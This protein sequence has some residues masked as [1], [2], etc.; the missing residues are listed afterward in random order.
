[1][2]TRKIAIASG[3][4]AALLVGS[5]GGFWIGHRGGDSGNA[6]SG[7][8]ARRPL[9]WVAPM[10]PNYRRNKPGKSPMGMDLVPVYANSGNGSSPS[11]VHISPEVVN[12]LGVQIATVKQGMFSRQTEAVGYVGYD[13]D[14][15]TSINTRAEG[16]I[17]KLSVKAEGDTVRKGQPLYELFSP[18][19][20]TAESEYLTALTSGMPSLVSASAE[21]LQALGFSAG[22]IQDLAKTRKASNRVTRYADME[23][24]IAKLGV[25][26][27]AYVTPAT[28]VMKI[29]DLSKVWVFVEADQR[30][31]AILKIGQK[32][33]AQ[34]DAFPGQIWKGLIDYIYP[35]IDAATRTAKVRLRFDNLD[36]KLQPN[37]YAHVFVGATPTDNA[38]FIPNSALIQSG[39][40]QRVAVALGDGRFDICP[41]VAGL[42][43]GDNVEILKGLKPGQK[44]VVSSQFL[45]DSEANLDAAALR[46]GYNK[47]GC[48]G[49][50]PSTPPINPQVAPKPAQGARA[51]DMT[52]MPGM[53]TM[54]NMAPSAAKRDHK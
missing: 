11:D 48:E 40:S 3:I 25:R 42:E 39:D 44:V 37:M 36:R 45:I 5:V 17:E 9:Y 22:Q 24:V 30:K 2:K 23:G 51:P 14:L 1:M 34:F 6:S 13:E 33:D 8:A 12:D 53:K 43:S 35:D 21:R 26:E 50:P 19:R 16:W 47:S 18:K 10:D 46:M 54:P 4:L 28:E 20:A 7:D 38:V 52:A 15:I 49:Q 29:A 31:A 32:V 27:G 41:V